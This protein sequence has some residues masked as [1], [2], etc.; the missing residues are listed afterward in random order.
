MASSSQ[1]LKRRRLRGGLPQETSFFPKADFVDF[2]VVAVN[3]TEQEPIVGEYGEQANTL[4]EELRVSVT[5]DFKGDVETFHNVRV[6]GAGMVEPF[7]CPDSLKWGQLRERKTKDGKRSYI[8]LVPPESDE[9][10]DAVCDYII[11]NP[12]L[13]KRYTG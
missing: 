3:G 12:E 7:L 13:E 9:E 5:P 2:F 11:A 10:K 4:I 8:T 6:V 1:T